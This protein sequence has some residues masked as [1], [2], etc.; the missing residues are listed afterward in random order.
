MNDYT[1]AWLVLTDRRW[2]SSM[3]TIKIHTN[4]KPINLYYE[5]WGS[6]KPVILIHGWPLDHQMWEHQLYELPQHGIRCIAYDRRGFGKSDK[7]WEKYDYN[8]LASDL[9]GLLEGL[10]I[11]DATLVGFSMGGG[12]VAR[13]LGRYGSE[14]VSKAVFISSVTPL[15]VKKDYNPDGVDPSQLDMMV[16]EITADRPKFLATFGRQFYGEGL[17][18]SPVS[19]ELL[20]WTSAMALQ[21]SLKA[22]VECIRAF[23]ETEFYGDLEQINIPTLVIHGDADKTVP[24]A[25]TGKETARLIPNAELSVFPDAP[26]GLFVTHRERLNHELVQFVKS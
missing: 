16:E 25:T 23:S 17:L 15:L 13:Y 7:P 24:Y 20:Q 26:H 9:H 18:T 1:S 22:S 4:G 19:E 11:T 14:R 10:N 3:S 5:D 6:G 12:E 8:T 2:D 21:S